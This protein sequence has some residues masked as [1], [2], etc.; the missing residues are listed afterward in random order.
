V[1]DQPNTRRDLSKLRTVPLDDA[2]HRR[3]RLYCHGLHEDGE[4]GE[5][6]ARVAGEAVNAWIDG[7][8]A[9][10][11]M[12][13]TSASIAAESVRAM[14]AEAGDP[15]EGEGELYGRWRQ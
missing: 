6:L 12:A 9:P 5:T 1:T 2:T 10:T 3:L 15:S 11:A 14:G 8:E 4:A 13:R 7:Q